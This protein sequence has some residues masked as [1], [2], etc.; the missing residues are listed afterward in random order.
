MA[1]IPPIAPERDKILNLSKVLI[2]AFLLV[3]ASLVFWGAIRA[4]SLLARNDNPRG[5]EAELRIQRGTV[6]DRSGRALALNEGTSDEQRRRYPLPAGGHLVGY[7][8]LLH[9]TSGAEAGFDFELRGET[10]DFWSD[11]IRQTLHLPQ[12]GR[13][14]QLALDYAAQETAEA[15]LGERNGGALLLELPRDGENRAWIR[16]LASLPGYDANQLDDTFEE[17]GAAADA[18]LLNRVTQGQYQPGMLLQPFILATSIDAGIVRLAD[19]VAEAARPVPINGSALNCA[20]A[21]PDPATWADVLYYR[22]PAPMQELADRIGPGGLDVAFS[23][24]GFDR[25]P[26]LEID[27]E[28][29]PGQ[30]LNNPLLAA[31]GQENLSVTPLQIGLAMSA[32]AADGSLPQAQVASAIADE[33]GE[34][35]PWLLE[36]AITQATS[37]STA[38]ALRRALPLENGIYE[39]NPLV[40]SGPEGSTNAWYVGVWPGAESDFVAVVVLEEG[41]SEGEAAASGRALLEMVRP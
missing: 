31:I 17:L 15:A 35:Q 13:D 3:G 4:D 16:A 37:A 2:G 22:C 23:A 10:G 36:G 20:A 6:V 32:L 33:Q 19:P 9:G 1:D 18:P 39:L 24:F 26:V 30:P 40:L 12:T 29:T 34:W 41:A 14:V 27:T 38:R 21:P 7:Y 28:T 25:D 5:V 8:S 11:Q